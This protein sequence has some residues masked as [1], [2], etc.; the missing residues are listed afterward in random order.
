MFQM[1][2]PITGEHFLTPALPLFLR[3]ASPL[4]DKWAGFVSMSGNFNLDNN[5]YDHTNQLPIYA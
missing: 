5:L 1:F 2:C 3:D 4:V